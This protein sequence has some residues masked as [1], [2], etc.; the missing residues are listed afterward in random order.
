MKSPYDYE[1]KQTGDVVTCRVYRDGELVH[2]KTFG[3]FELPFLRY[4]RTWNNTSPK[5][6]EWKFEAAHNHGTRLIEVLEEQEKELAH[7][8]A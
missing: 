7:G 6:M 2:E 3:I 4:M 8:Q 5:V 1:V